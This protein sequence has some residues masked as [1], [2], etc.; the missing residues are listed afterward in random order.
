MF[1]KIFAKLKFSPAL[2][3]KI[4][5]FVCLEFKI[6]KKINFNIAKFVFLKNRPIYKNKLYQAVTYRINDYL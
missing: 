1:K 3:E 6:E 4:P 5:S 2:L